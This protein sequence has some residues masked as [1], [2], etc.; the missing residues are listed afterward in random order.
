MRWAYRIV[1]AASS[2][3]TERVSRRPTSRPVANATAT[4]AQAILVAFWSSSVAGGK[5]STLARRAQ[6]AGWLDAVAPPAARAT[7]T[8][9]PPPRRLEEGG[10]G[11]GPHLGVAEPGALR[12]LVA[13]HAEVFL[14][15]VKKDDRHDAENPNEED[16]I[17]ARGP[18]RPP[19]AVEQ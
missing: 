3:S 12:P 6:S 14:E 19:T 9:H 8:I 1:I 18:K 2:Y 15:D 16:E 7:R 5:P 11:A 17:G 4:I 13:A 10:V